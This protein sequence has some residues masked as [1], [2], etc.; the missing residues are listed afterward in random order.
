MPRLALA[1]AFCLA[2]IGPASALDKAAFQKEEEKFAAA[3]N[4]GDVAAV[5]EFYV[6][7]AYLLP[8]GSE[9][10]QGRSNIQ[11]FWKKMIEQGSDLKLTTVDVKPLGSDAARSI[12]TF[13]YKTKGQQPQEV[14]GKYVLVLQRIGDDWKIETDIFNGD[15]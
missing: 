1:A 12:G 4:R 15:R 3:L 9:I 7:N 14:A 8:P 11:A 6:E 5:A 13:T 2:V 10:V